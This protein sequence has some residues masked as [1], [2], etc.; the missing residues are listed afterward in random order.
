LAEAHGGMNLAELQAAGI[1]PAVLLDVSTNVSPIGAPPAV[2]RA[3]ATL[4]PAAYPDPRCSALVRRLAQQLDVREDRILC[5]NGSSELI[6]LLARVFVRSGQ[7]PVALAPTFGEYYTA[8]ELAGGMVYEWRSRAERGFRP[9][10]KNKP[11]VLRRVTPPLVWLCNPNN[12]TGV[13]LDRRDVEFLASTLTGG[14]LALDEAYVNFLD[15]PW[16]S[17]DLV[18][19]RRVIV[20]RS[21]TKDYGLA[22]LRLGYIVA[23]QDVIEA[24]RRLQPPWSVSAAAQLAGLAALD[25]SGHLPRMRA[26]VREGKAVL[27]DGLRDM[28]LDVFAGSVNFVLIKAGDGGELRARMLRRG[29]Q[30]RDCA[31][32]GLPEYIRIGVRLPEAMRRVLSVLREALAEGP[33]VQ[34]A[35]AP[36]ESQPSE[37]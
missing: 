30:V 2:A 21:M 3:L 8:T 7:R 14:P 29:V 11:D 26:A 20:L 15:D 12:P 16:R 33:L 32:F 23:H 17:L 9:V 35:A 25:D 31:S 18:G 6:H 34:P 19:N 10:L 24:M 28:P 37:E 1:D 4:D 36:T 27:L 13:Y 5:G 22:G